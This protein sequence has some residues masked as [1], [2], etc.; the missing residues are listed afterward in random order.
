MI[1]TQADAI[2]LGACLVKHYLPDMIDVIST[3]HMSNDNV[4]QSY[5]DFQEYV[6]L[7]IGVSQDIKRDIAQLGIKSEKIY[8]MCVP[9]DCDEIL[10]RT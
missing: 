6:D 5:M 10:V 4:Y 2:T 7:H 3:I 8:S 9:F 1:I